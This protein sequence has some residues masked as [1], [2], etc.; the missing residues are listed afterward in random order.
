M[1]EKIL[2]M[3]IG[4]TSIKLAIVEEDQIIKFTSYKNIWKSKQDQMLI[5]LKGILTRWIQE[6]QITKIGIGCPGDIKDNV[7][8]FAANLNWKDFHLVDQLHEIFPNLSIKI[9][10]DGQAATL[11]EMNYGLLKGVENGIFIV[12]GR[13]VGGSLILNHQIYQG[14]NQRGGNFGHMVIKGPKARKCNCGRKGCFETY[15][16]VAGLIQTIKETNYRSG[17]NTP[18]GKL[19]GL[20]ISELAHNQNPII[21]KAIKQW[22]KDIA[23][24]ILSLTLIIDPSHIVL[25]GGITE[26]GLIDLDEIK[27]KLSEQGFDH[28]VVEISKFR[29]KAGVVGAASLHKE[30]N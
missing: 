28:V 11:A 22:N 17:Q 25:A 4:G 16:S 18:L 24:S 21:L 8:V 20:R 12:F 13:G 15:A 30:N 1:S 3:D 9:A 7:V 27:N 14:S 19:G 5:D 2:A 10:N 26:S 6:Y 23:E 29:G